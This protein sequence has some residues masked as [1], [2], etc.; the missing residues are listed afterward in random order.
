MELLSAFK[1]VSEK[2]QVPSGAKVS[3][4]CRSAR[5]ARQQVNSPE[6][7]IALLDMLRPWRAERV[8]EG[9]TFDF[10]KPLCNEL[11][12]GIGSRVELFSNI[13]MQEF[14]VSF[15]EADWS[16][17]DSLSVV[18]AL[19]AEL[20]QRAELMLQQESEQT[21]LEGRVLCELSTLN[22]GFASLLDW[23]SVATS[24]NMSEKLAA[25]S[26]I[27]TSQTEGDTTLSLGSLALAL[28]AKEELEDARLILI[29]KKAALLS[30]GRLVQAHMAVWRR[31]VH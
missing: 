17:G 1:K 14:M 28:E 11:G 16:L 10:A 31:W 27:V 5:K 4:L 12:M 9:T 19:V 24:A 29:E 30:S 2:C 22:V 18:K 6:R 21:E 26:E 20:Q 23:K 3:V 15:T 25:V 13:F 8:D 7:A